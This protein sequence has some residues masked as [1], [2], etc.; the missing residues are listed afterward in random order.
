MLSTLRWLG[1][2]PSFSRPR[3]SNDNPYSEALFRTVKYRPEYPNKPFE[4]I[5]AARKWV[6]EFVGWYNDRHRH[7]AI[8]FVTP[9]QKHSGEE[10]RVLRKR[11]EV[12]EQARK[13]RPSRWT[14]Q[15]RNWTPVEKVVLNPSKA[16]ADRA[17]GRQKSA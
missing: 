5:D 12:Y 14:R 7:S 16:Q 13:L 8:R 11:T 4:S 3:V 9:S 2:V 10:K 17:P 1:I 6:S 15:A